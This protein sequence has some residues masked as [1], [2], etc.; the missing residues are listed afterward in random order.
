MAVNGNNIIVYT[1]SNNGSS[2]TAVAAVK[3]DEIQVD[4]E[5]IEISSST[6]GN[7]VHRIMGRMSWG[8]NTSWLVTSVSDIEKVLSVGTR[9]KVH[10]GARGYSGGS[11]GLTGF[12]FIRSSKVTMTRGALANGSFVFE[13]D[14]PL[15]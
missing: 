11:G 14:G 1:S 10:V 8:L 5:T 12:A 13:G 3:S 4:G 6:D 2:W 15:A 9:V 7:W